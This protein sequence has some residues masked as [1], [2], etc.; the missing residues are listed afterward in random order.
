MSGS[1]ASLQPNLVSGRPQAPLGGA[2]AGGD[3]LLTDITYYD[4]VPQ[5]AQTVKKLRFSFG[6]EAFAD[7]DG[8]AATEN[9]GRSYVTSGVNITFH[10][11][12]H[13]PAYKFKS[14]NTYTV[15]YTA[16]PTQYIEFDTFVSGVFT[17]TRQ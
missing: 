10:E 5:G 8:S 11:V 14:T 2:I 12:C 17:Y 6:Y 9:I 3:Y 7:G 13:T 15:P 4:G 16:T 1:G